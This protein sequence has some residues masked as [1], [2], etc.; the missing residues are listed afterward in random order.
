MNYIYWWSPNLFKLQS[1]WKYMLCKC[2]KIALEIICPKSCW[3]ALKVFETVM[4]IIDDYYCI[5][6]LVPMGD[7]PYTWRPVSLCPKIWILRGSNVLHTPL[8]YSNWTARQPPLWLHHEQHCTILPKVRD[9]IT[10]TFEA[11][12]LFLNFSDLVPKAKMNPPPI[13]TTV[14]VMIR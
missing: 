8:R 13:S 6:L 4:I 10:E 1:A 12:C 9:E 5:T 14:Q 7:I 11:T 2:T 3:K